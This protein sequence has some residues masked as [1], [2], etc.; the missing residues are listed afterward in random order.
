MSD[1]LY[2]IALSKHLAFGYVDAPQL[3]PLLMA[4]SRFMFGE[5]LPALHIL[6][7]LAGAGTLGLDCL[8]AREFGGKVFAGGLTALA[9]LAV[10]VCLRRSPACEGEK[11]ERTQEYSG[12]SYGLPTIL[13][14]CAG[15]RGRHGGLPYLIDPVN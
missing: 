10:P 13:S 3:A 1:E 14:A 4:A 8:I 7:A 15:R 11:Q 2:T 12:Q 9:F 6:P 5:S